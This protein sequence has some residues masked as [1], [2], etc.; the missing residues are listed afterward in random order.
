MSSSSGGLLSS[1]SNATFNF[2]L[3][4]I[5]KSGLLGIFGLM[6]ME[7][8]TLPIPSETVLPLAGYLVYLGKADFWTVVVVASAGSIVGTMIDYSIGFYLGRAALLRYGRLIRLNEGHLEL[9]ERWFGRYGSSA[10]LAARFVPVVRTLIAFPAGLA[11]MKLG[12]F[13]AFSAVGV[14]AWDTML[15]Y[16]GVMAGRNGEAII[17]YLHSLFLPLGLAAIATIVI[18]VYVRWRR[19]LKASAS[20]DSRVNR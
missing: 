10:V 6:V 2:V 20:P 3:N 5:D 12:R 7:S 8:A 18:F 19:R 4:L 13:L 15:V 16:L 17:G 1:L 9:A 14:F 11:K